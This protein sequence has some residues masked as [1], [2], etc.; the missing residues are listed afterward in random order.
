[1][2][3]IAYLDNMLNDAGGVEQVVA[4]RVR[5]TWT[6]FRELSGILCTRGE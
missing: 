4:A 2:E 6:K 5:A 3:Y 1:M